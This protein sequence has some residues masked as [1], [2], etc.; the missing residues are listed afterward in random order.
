MAATG[1]SDIDQCKIHGISRL[2]EIKRPLLNK[3]I[4]WSG[5]IRIM[6]IGPQVAFR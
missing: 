3:W 2:L 1:S 5:I 4:D 6:Q